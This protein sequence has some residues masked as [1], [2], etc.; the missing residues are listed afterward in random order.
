MKTYKTDIGMITIHEGI[1]KLNDDIEINYD[2]ALY[3]VGLAVGLLVPDSLG[4]CDLMPVRKLVSAP[5]GLAW[6]I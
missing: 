6:W 1:A 2:S 4:R 3:H 5:V